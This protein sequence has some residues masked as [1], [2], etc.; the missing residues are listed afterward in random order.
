MK[1]YKENDYVL[2]KINK[3]AIVYR[4]G[5][6]TVEITPEVYL[7]EN[8]DKTEKDFAELKAL[9]DSIYFEQDRAEC[10]QTQKNVSL[11]VL[12]E[13]DFCSVPSPEDEMIEEMEETERTATKKRRREIGLAAFEMLTEVQRR[14]YILF[15]VE[16]VSTWEI[17]K[18]EGVNQSKI[19]KSLRLAEKKIKKYLTESEK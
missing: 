9:S 1:N 18:K 17:A 12:G 2:N 7:H 5:D 4:C 6:G 10:R 14:R 19:I 8:P 13:M 15:H 16:G 11:D 3:T